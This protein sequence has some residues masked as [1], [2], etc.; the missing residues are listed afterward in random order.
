MS[1]EHKLS[2]EE[3]LAEPEYKNLVI[4]DPDGWDR[5]PDNWSASWSEK[6]T[7][8]EFVSRLMFSTSIYSTVG[9]TDGKSP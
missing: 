3:W 4:V 5:T 8:E 9:T 1:E 7:R 2:A 6:I